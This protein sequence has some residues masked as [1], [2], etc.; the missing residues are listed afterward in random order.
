MS[1]VVIVI[2]IISVRS[3]LIADKVFIVIGQVFCPDPV[4]D[5]V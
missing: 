5:G 1:K 4:N 3:V 2:Y